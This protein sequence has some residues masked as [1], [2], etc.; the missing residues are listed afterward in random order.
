MK[1][2]RTQFE[3][4]PLIIKERGTIDALVD[5]WK[6]TSLHF[7][8]MSSVA[9]RAGLYRAFQYDVAGSFSKQY[10]RELRAA[11]KYEVRYGC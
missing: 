2:D 6:L 11:L 1:T 3:F 8:T 5:E 7:K 4:K 10:R 9:M